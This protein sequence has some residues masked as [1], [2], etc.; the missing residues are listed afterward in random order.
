M[1]MTEVRAADY[2]F[3]VGRKCT[4]EMVDWNDGIFDS[5]V[6]GQNEDFV[7]YLAN[8]KRSRKVGALG[9]RY[10][11]SVAFSVINEKA[12]PDVRHFMGL[13][14]AFFK[15]Q[16][17]NIFLAEKHFFSGIFGRETEFLGVFVEVV[18]NTA[19][20]LTGGLEIELDQI[21][22]IEMKVE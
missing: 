16:L 7:F 19:V 13:D 20:K 15:H 1:A 11:Q 10:I 8:E 5:Y 4:I 18:D 21:A 22:K 17:V 14:W 12:E 9:K 2:R 6:L 3:F